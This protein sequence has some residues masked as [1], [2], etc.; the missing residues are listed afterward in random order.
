MN[1][2]ILV[3]LVLLGLMMKSGDFSYAAESK[4][5]LKVLGVGDSTT[6]GMPGFR[7]PA[8]APPYGN[9]DET[10]Q[11]AYWIMQRHPEWQVMNR[12]ISG[13]RSDEILARLPQE[14]KRVKP[15]VVIILA[16]VNDVYQGRSAESVKSNLKKMY[17]LASKDG[18][19]LVVCT[20]LAYN[21]ADKNQRK[22]I[23]HVNEWIRVQAKTHGFIFCDTFRALSSLHGPFHLTNSP[24][25]MHPSVDDYKRMGNA[26]TVALEKGIA[27]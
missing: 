12:G 18:C 13:Q 15:D 2:K 19:K 1:H 27:G 11:Y 8:E 4:K 24:D 6:A 22:Q 23:I 9:G 5:N 25:G 20:I 14:L 21:T 3:V 26:I 10:S 16:G 7:S 17:Q